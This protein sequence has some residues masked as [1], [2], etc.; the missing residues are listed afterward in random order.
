MSMR[1]PRWPFYY[2]GG[3]G[4]AVFKTALVTTTAARIADGY[5]VKNRNTTC[6]MHQNNNT[7][8]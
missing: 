6:F 1:R 3:L 5:E 8:S 2:L 4:A 7:A